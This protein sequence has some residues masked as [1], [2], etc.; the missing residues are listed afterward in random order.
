MS[1]SPQKTRKLGWCYNRAGAMIEKICHVKHCFIEGGLMS[2][3]RIDYDLT[4]K[5]RSKAARMRASPTASKLSVNRKV[6]P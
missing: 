1:I 5:K 4:V 6:S 3:V 2:A